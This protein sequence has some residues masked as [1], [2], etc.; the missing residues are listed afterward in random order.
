MT[1]TMSFDKWKT[2]AHLRAHDG[3]SDYGSWRINI[4]GHATPRKE[5]HYLFAKAPLTEI[6]KPS[7]DKQDDAATAATGCARK[8]DATAA[9][10]CA[11]KNNAVIAATWRDEIS[12][13][14]DLNPNYPRDPRPY[15]PP[16][17]L[18][19]KH[20]LYGLID[21]PTL[22]EKHSDS[23]QQV[24][25]NSTSRSSTAPSRHPC[26]TAPTTSPRSRPPEITAP[27]GEPLPPSTRLPW[28]TR[29]RVSRH[30]SGKAKS[31]TSITTSR[32]V[33]VRRLPHLKA[34]SPT[35]RTPYKPHHLRRATAS[36][37]RDA[38]LRTY[39]VLSVNNCY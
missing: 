1:T 28:P 31:S 34:A 25:R 3:G 6:D 26:I 11:R 29:P 30:S 37:H 13:G 22:Y 12:A 14:W 39:L 18:R 23:L 27:E 20:T 21:A 9:T 16:M 5:W 32:H 4:L 33:Y 2:H 36:S 7:D 35:T 38:H 8:I 10:G 15:R 17:T 24:I 19:F